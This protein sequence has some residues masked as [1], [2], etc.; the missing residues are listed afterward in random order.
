MSHT[1]WLTPLLSDRTRTF[2]D[3]YGSF[4][5]WLEGSYGGDTLLLWMSNSMIEEVLPQIPKQFKGRIVLGLD[6]SDN[7]TLPFE[8]ALYWVN[9]RRALAVGPGEGLGLG[10]AGQ[11]E[12]ED[13]VWVSW[14]DSRE[15]RML[16]V[17]LHPGFSYLEPRAYAP[18]TAPALVELPEIEG[19]RVGSSGW[20]K[21]I[22]T[23]GIG[24]HNLAKNLEALLRAWNM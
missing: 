4:Y 24:L 6:V 23:Y 19:P 22:P 5:A 10:F 18:W 16:E 2:T 12:V 9:P 21:G 11:K 7:H 13:G 1:D 8:R 15:A 3:E 14:E 20:A 17:E